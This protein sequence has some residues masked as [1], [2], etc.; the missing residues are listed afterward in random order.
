MKRNFELK[1]FAVS[2]ADTLNAISFGRDFL[3]E[4]RNDRLGKMN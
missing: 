4:R 2:H 1:H 3:P